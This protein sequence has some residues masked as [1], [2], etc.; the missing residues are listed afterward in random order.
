[1]IAFF[2]VRYAGGGAVSVE[3]ASKERCE[4]AIAALDRQSTIFAVCVQK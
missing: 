1:M 3:F 2:A 4:A